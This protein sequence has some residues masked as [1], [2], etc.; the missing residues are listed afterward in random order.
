MQNLRNSASTSQ[1]INGINQSKQ[2][3][4]SAKGYPF[5]EISKAFNE[6]WEGK[7][8][9]KKGIGYKPFKRWEHYWS[10]FVDENGFL[11]S[12]S[13]LWQ[14]GLKRERDANNTTNPTSDW[15]SIGPFISQSQ[16]QGQPGIGRINA[17]AVDP[18]NENIWFAGA[19]AG[20]LWR[21]LDAGDSWE[22]VFDDFPQIGVS[23]IAIDPTN[24]NII[25]IATGDDD[26]S[27]S[28]SV[29]VFKSLDGGNTWNE[30]GL[31]P[32]NTANFNRMN[33]IFINPNN[34]N[35]V[36]VA[37]NGGL[38]RSL[39]GGDTWQIVLNQDVRDFRLKPGDPNTIYAVTFDRLFISANGGDNFAP[40]TDPNLPSSV[41]N[42][43]VL[44]VTEAN[45]E[46][47]YVL[48]GDRA[49]DDDDAFVGLFKS[50]N[51][52]QT[53]APTL[54]TQNIVERNQVFYDFTMAISPT[55]EDVIFTG[56]INIWR[57]VN[58]GNNFTR[59]NNNDNNVG[60][61]YTHVDIH[62]LKFFNNR[63]FTGT[64]GGL[65]V[66][67]DNGN[68]FLNRTNGI[69][70]SQFYK[71]SVS[72]EDSNFI[73]G[74]TQ[75]NS[76]F[77][78]NGVDW[79]VYTGGDGMDYEIDPNNE[80]LVYGFTQFG[81]FL[82]ISTNQGQTISGLA[83]SPV[84]TTDPSIRGRWI[85]PL[86]INNSGE[87]FS[88]YRQI[89]RLDGNQW[90]LISPDFIASEGI[91]DME[92]DQNNDSIVYIADQ[93]A[94]LRSDDGGVTFSTVTILG[95]RISDIELNSN[96]SNIVYLTT[97]FTL[98]NGQR[99]QP[100]SRGVFRVN[101]DENDFSNSTVDNLTLNL[102]NNLAFFTV[103]HQ[104]NDQNNPI[105]VGTNL[106]VYRLD[107]TLTEWENYFTNL[108]ATAVGDLEFNLNENVLVAGTYGRG[109]WISPVPNVP[110]ENDIEVVSVIPGGNAIL[111][112]EI[113]P[114]ITVSNNGTNE[115]NTVDI[116]FDINGANTQTTTFTG[117]I[118]VNETIAIPLPPINVQDFGLNSFNVTVTLAN[119]DITTNN[120]GT[121]QF[122][123]N[124]FGIGDELNTFETEEDALIAFNTVGP[125]ESVWE[126]GVPTGNILNQASSGNQV[127]ATNLDGNHP[128][129]T[130]SVLVSNCYE[131]SSIASPV[132]RF[133]MAFDLEI[134]FDIV[135]VEY[136]TNDGESWNILGNI[137]STPNWYN[138]DRTNQ[139][140]GAANDCQNCPGA[141]WTGTEA[142]LTEYAYDFTANAANG[143]TDLTNE[144]N[145]IFRIVFQSDPAVTQEGAIIDDFIVEGMQDDDDDDNDGI[146][147]VDDNCPLIGN[148]N[149]ANMDGD[150][151]GD[152]CDNCP[153]IPNND[154]A[155][156]DGD[157]IGDA[158]ETDIDNDG[159]PNEF[160]LCPNTPEGS[161][162]DVDG[163]AVFSLPASN[164][165]ILTIGESCINNENG[166]VQIEA[167]ANLNYTAVLEGVGNSFST[168][169]NFTDTINFT[170]LSAGSY[171]LCITVE[172]EA[173]Y[174]NCLDISIVQPD[175]LN[176]NTSVSTLNNEVTLNL[177][178]GDNYTIT[179][180]GKVINTSSTE[181]TLALP[182]VENTLQVRTDRD[183]QGI[184]TETIIL[185]PEV[186]IYPN[187]ISSGN[188]TVLIGKQDETAIT[189]YVALY[190]LEGNEIFGKPIPVINGK[191]EFNIDGLAT[192][193]Y[194][195]NV[196]TD[197]TLSNYKIIRK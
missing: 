147:D 39:D 1:S 54:T 40:A 124:D 165:S 172:N 156:F 155:D 108:P 45:P 137:N 71:I 120:T 138:S 69:A 68:T 86:E 162:V 47:L 27:D 35:I 92:I 182:N 88:A 170:D 188:L 103:A 4:N 11:P 64:D 197:N 168:T 127:Y 99:G 8:I 80:N 23:G 144:D 167:E 52:G 31:N 116:S 111:C 191:V 65:Y 97:S 42:R 21:S 195:L 82:F 194:I 19:P 67:D 73:A 131:L 12:A 16:A 193:I 17:I 152:V 181:I 151:L 100:A 146:L 115:I 36:W 26:A 186:F 7:D 117:V 61:A 176:V 180:N 163:C 149:Q 81:G 104:G 157:G 95:S 171:T 161:T 173:D 118:G 134:N 22:N 5:W 139:S 38:Q 58:G 3:P 15:T 33:E 62:T 184:H 174:E 63:L 119:E 60:P 74:G 46:V 126:R 192:G 164:F 18:N 87:V 91:I 145:I 41:N 93:G 96:D 110:F 135:F 136:S 2:N 50:S 28:F 101:V 77:V 53:F 75:D 178:G 32:S 89:Y 55:D 190:S 79:N 59:L 90:N 166:M 78:F 37:T 14:D 113:F 20:G 57:S 51:S 125:L 49:A 183:C 94:L 9:T 128:D 56:A 169:L 70:I 133:T 142:T 84:G 72:A 189:S 34:T 143:E 122:Y 10:H 179:L 153:T 109:A 154:Q 105:F 112:G 177:S 185:N 141:Q 175:A 129:G 196:K 121:S 187:P 98:E 102:P 130:T 150:N 48:I 132:L 29:G 66:S 85:T 159:V 13:E 25:Y 6:Y 140:S 76:G 83:Q 106:G 43:M 44:G 160:D 114:E 148:A 123:F 158:C 24:S 30:T 107:D